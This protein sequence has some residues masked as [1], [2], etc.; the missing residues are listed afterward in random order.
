MGRRGRIGTSM[1]THRINRAKCQHT[2][3][4]WKRAGILDATERR[5][6]TKWKRIQ[7]RKPKPG[8]LNRGLSPS[9]HP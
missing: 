7:T 6:C 3:T 2:W 8:E 5:E 4:E 1:T 9:I